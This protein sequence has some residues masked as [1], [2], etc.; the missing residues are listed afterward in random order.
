[1]PQLWS[2]KHVDGSEPAMS[3]SIWPW[4]SAII[5]VTKPVPTVSTRYT[6]SNFT[7]ATHYIIP[8]LCGLC[9]VLWANATATA[10]A[11]SV[12]TRR[13]FVLTPLRPA[14][15]PLASYRIDHDNHTLSSCVTPDSVIVHC[16]LIIIHSRLNPAILLCYSS[17]S[18]CIALIIC[19]I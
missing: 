4:L 1:M 19:G 16:Q 8:Q 3:Q 12:P 11:S 18:N 6:A 17:H 7:K 10:I 5:Q 14:P 9:C 2:R 13:P 15:L